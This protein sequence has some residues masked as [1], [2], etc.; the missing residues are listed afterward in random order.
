MTFSG[1]GPGAMLIGPAVTGV[2][3]WMNGEA[4]KYYEE[5]PQVIYRSTKHALNE[6][7]LPITKDEPQDNTFYILA[8]DK[9]RFSINIVASEANMSKM[10]IR[11]NFL[12]D[13]DLA[14]LI[15]KKV[16]QQLNSIHFDDQGNPTRKSRRN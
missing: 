6:L 14:E 16:D 2:I 13:K 11:I 15:Y 10:S 8:G 12:G 9:D 7:N 3:Y 1:C 4:H 5:S